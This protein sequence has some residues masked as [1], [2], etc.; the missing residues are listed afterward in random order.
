M[1]HAI[2]LASV[3]VVALTSGYVVAEPVSGRQ[4]QTVRDRMVP[5]PPDMTVSVW[6]SGLSIPWSI[7]F[8]PDGTALVSE[9]RG[10]ILLLDQDGSAHQTPYATPQVIA[11]GEGGLM[12][13]AL[14]PAFPR[15]P[16]VY[17]MLTHRHDGRTV[18]AVV[19]L[20]H[21]GMHGVI[22]R[23]ILDDLPAGSIHNGGRIA[24][25]PDGLLYVATGETGKP[26]L[27][28]DRASLAGKILRIRGDGSV[29]DDNPFPGSPVFTLGHRNVQG[30]AWRPGTRD[31]Y[32]SEHGPSGEFNLYARD[33]IN[34]IRAGGNY[35]WPAATCAVRNK[36]FVDPISCWPE[37][38]IAPSGMTFFHGDLFVATLRGEALIRI[39][40]GANDRIESIERWFASGEQDGRYGRLRD[41]ATGP[42]GA[43]YV[44]TNSNCGGRGPVSGDCI[45]KLTVK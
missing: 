8:L 10:R 25:G 30:F 13:L 14:D 16:Y 24:F 23:T 39:K 36:G 19:R 1:R 44:L 7:V 2:I 4:P 29:P 12:G 5:E 33:E 17:A 37:R 26:D 9:R 20:R 38:A 27:A 21:E 28:A 11:Q 3:I 32:A 41:A 18:N 31:F 42:D 34:R 15:S 40:I 6:A 43:L 22:D 45:L 35:G